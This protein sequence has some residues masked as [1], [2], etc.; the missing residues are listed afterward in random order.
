MSP[1][2]AWLTLPPTERR[3][4]QK[5][6]W[7]GIEIPKQGTAESRPPHGRLSEVRAGLPG[8]VMSRKSR[9]RDCDGDQVNEIATR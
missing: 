6:V 3:A 2:G 9:A 8:A 1:S 7:A 5:A 4:N